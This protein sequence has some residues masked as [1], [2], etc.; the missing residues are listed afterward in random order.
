MATSKLDL[1]LAG[2]HEA[3]LMI[4]GFCD[5][6]TEEEMLTAVEAGHKAIASACNDIQAWVDKVRAVDNVE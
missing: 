4:E 2:T 6:L 1:V 3:I 5:F